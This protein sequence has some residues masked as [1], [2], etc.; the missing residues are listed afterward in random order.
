MTSV[1]QKLQVGGFAPRQPTLTTGFVCGFE[2]TVPYVCSYVKM[3]I[4][5]FYNVHG[6]PYVHERALSNYKTAS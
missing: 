3:T 1:A 2:M 6:D 4:F 5:T